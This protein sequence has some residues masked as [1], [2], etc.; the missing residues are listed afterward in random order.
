MIPRGEGMRRTALI[1][2]LPLL[3]SSM[4]T[5][6]LNIRPSGAES[7]TPSDPA[8]ARCLQKGLDLTGFESGKLIV[9]TDASK[10]EM[11]ELET[12]IFNDGGSVTDTILVGENI[13]ALV[14]EVPTNH[15]YEFAE[16]LWTNKLVAYI[17]PNGEVEACYSPNDPD[18]LYQWGPRKIEADWA[19]NT[20]VG[21]SD[22]LVAI[23]DTGIDYTHSDLAPNYAPLGYDWMNNDTDPMDDCGHGTHCAGIVAA[24]LNNGVG[25]A[26]LAQV[27]IMA[28]KVLDSTGHGN[29]SLLIKGIYHAIDAGAKILSLSLGGHGNSTTLHNAVR[30]AYDHGVL[31]IAAA[32]NDGWQTRLYPAA[33][34]EAVAVSATDQDD[35]LAWFSTYG[36]WI[37]LAAPGVNIYSALPSNAYGSKNGT[38]MACPHVTG[39]AALSWTAFENYTVKQIRRLMEFDAEDLGDDGYDPYYGYGLVN[40]RRS[41]TVG[42]PEHDVRITGWQHPPILNPGQAG[43]FNITVFNYGLTNETDVSV[44]FL[45]NSTLID[46][47]NIGLEADASVSVSFSWNTTTLGVYNVT[48]FVVPVPG[49]NLTENNAISSIMPVRFP[50]TLMVPQDYP[51]IQMAINNAFDEDTILVRNGTYSENIVVN[52]SVSL[53]GED[54]STTTIKGDGIRDIVRITASNANFSSFKVT[55]NIA[56]VSN[57]ERRAINLVHSSGHN[58]SGNIIENGGVWGILVVSSNSNVISENTILPNLKNVYQHMGIMLRESSYNII[59]CNVITENKHGGMYGIALVAA[60]H[61]VVANNQIRDFRLSSIYFD[62]PLIYPT[63][64]TSNIIAD[65]LM[66]GSTYGVYSYYSTNNNSICRNLVIGN[67]V[68]V[69]FYSSNS[70]NNIFYHNSFISNTVQVCRKDTDNFWDN[71]LEG[72]YWSDYN[73]T[74]AN[75]DEIGDTPYI[76]YGNNTDRY[77]LME[78][79][80]SWW[81]CYLWNPADVDHDLDVDIFDVVQAARAYGSTSSDPNWN[82]C[83]DIAEP[84]GKID[85]FDLVMIAGSYG[86]DYS[87]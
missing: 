70:R 76:V 32:G 64:C 73:G 68:G 43:T 71:G 21:S 80:L 78:P 86:K 24:T 81:S 75:G 59:S 2:L 20:T 72:N 16:K 23:I 37:D 63:P 44:Q 85:I 30:Y 39:V 5:V 25:I 46:F 28:E 13:Q 41:V 36:P 51:T 54:A 31:V 42:L 62:G 66:S 35:N 4:L 34:E 77:P 55:E 58:I 12:T 27:R 3:L 17:E 48:C 38:S 79:I 9:G 74:D 61:N 45:V 50:T 53:V 33:F 56:N 57:D 18:W 47:A 1:V 11:Q 40:A 52:K 14:V 15:V 83:C 60:S 22:L 7:P 87:N 29:Y 84:Y 65:N 19:W 26:G 82:P 49:E 69:Y 67:Q 8:Y 10:P 6:V